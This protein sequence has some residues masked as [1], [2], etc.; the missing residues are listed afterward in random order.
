[1]I[2]DW[3][4]MEIMLTSSQTL[5][6]MTIK[7]T[8]PL[9]NQTILIH[10]TTIKR[11]QL[12]TLILEKKTCLIS[13]MPTDMKMNLIMTNRFI[14]SQWKAMKGKTILPLKALMMSSMKSKGLKKWK[15]HT[16]WSRWKKRYIK[17]LMV[18]FGMNI[19]KSSERRSI[20][21]TKWHIGLK[22][23]TDLER[24]SLRKSMHWTRRLLI[25]LQITLI[26]SMKIKWRYSTVCISVFTTTTQT[27]LSFSE[28]LSRKCPTDLTK[29][30]S[31]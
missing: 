5:I 2:S 16:K 7:L 13:M 3:I 18:I 9:N 21:I 14:L 22:R 1:M 25:L 6:K 8:H 29:S 26:T 27:W 20:S 11:K 12:K 24:I 10:S 15:K 31:C 17:N 30:T 19:C 4:S 23:L 28:L